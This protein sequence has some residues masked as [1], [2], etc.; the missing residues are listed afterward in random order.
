MP[1]TEFRQ[2]LQARNIP[3]NKIESYVTLV[4]QF[5]DFRGTVQAFA[6]RLIQEGNNTRDNFYALMFYGEC[7]DDK[8]ILVAA[9]SI[10]DGSEVLGNLYERL[11]QAAG[12]AKRDE[13]F[14][15]ITLPPLGT[16]HTELP[17]YTRP[18]MDRLER[19]VDPAVYRPLL[20]N[21]LRTLK[22]EWFLEDRKKYL[23][24]GNLDAFL[25]WK[26]E[27][28]IT[29]LEQLKRDGKLFFT[30]EI[31]DDVLDYVR[32]HPEIA[33]GI[34]KDGDLIVTKIPYMPQDY[35]DETDEQ[36]KRYYYC[37]CPWVRESLQPGESPVSSTFC[38]CS[39]GFM[40]KSWEVIFDQPLQA[41]VLET[42]VDGGMQCTFAIHLP[43]GV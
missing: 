40:K 20:L 31:T 12:T 4:E 37:H 29:M 14:E 22:S 39:A 21:C 11:A 43:P 2:F 36:M 15:G 23:E 35:L 30:L 26:K 32:A 1:P 27:E 28:F 8:E 7:I 38:C 25:E 18:V 13:V 41:D 6:A 42:V 16:P 9:L 3:A 24:I 5:E 33:V 19:M 34:R 17:S 10:L